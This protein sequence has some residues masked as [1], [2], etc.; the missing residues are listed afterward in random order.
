MNIHGGKCY[1]MSSIKC[2][3]C[4]FK[5]KRRGENLKYLEKELKTNKYLTFITKYNFINI[6]IIYNNDFILE[7]NICKQGECMVTTWTYIHSKSYSY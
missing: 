7:I 4:Q 6:L 5:S 3:K 2:K 1:I